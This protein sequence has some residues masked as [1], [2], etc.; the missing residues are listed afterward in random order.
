MEINNNL[1]GE[2]TRKMIKL[3]EEDEKKRIDE[4]A[5]CQHLFVKLKSEPINYYGHNIDTVECVHCGLTNKYYG[6]EKMI[7][8][9]IASFDYTLLQK[10][11]IIKFKLKDTT[12]ESEMMMKLL[13]AKK[14]L[15]LLS[16]EVIETNHAGLLYQIAKKIEPLSSNN[17]LFSI[18]QK[19]NKLETLEEKNNLSNIFDAVD[20][21]NRYQNDGKILKK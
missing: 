10:R 19:L 18:M 6:I 21:I 11:N 15:I 16:D 7:R 20:L 13:Q 12:I 1:L 4:I 14:E 9:Y 3:S 5:N 8:K 2:C 17:E